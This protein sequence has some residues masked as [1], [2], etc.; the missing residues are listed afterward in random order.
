LLISAT[1]RNDRQHQK[2]AIQQENCIPFEGKDTGFAADNQNISITKLLA[3]YKT[4][5]E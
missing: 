4:G 1:G 3:K 5:K 2:T